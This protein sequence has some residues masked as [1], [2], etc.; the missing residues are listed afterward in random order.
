MD[1]PTQ[2]LHICN[3]QSP[4]STRRAEVPARVPRRRAV[5][6]FLRPGSGIGGG[7]QSD[8]ECPR[9]TKRQRHHRRG[10]IAS[11]PRWQLARERVLLPALG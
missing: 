11:E 7:R 2:E 3:L 6:S 9:A 10:P 4:A 8:R 5:G 1:Q